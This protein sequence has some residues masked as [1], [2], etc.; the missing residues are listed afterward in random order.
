MV[1]KIVI[2]NI[3]MDII[4]L[5]IMAIRTTTPIK[6]GFIITIIIIIQLIALIKHRRKV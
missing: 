1:M 3:K 5:K 6:A 4:L 2:S